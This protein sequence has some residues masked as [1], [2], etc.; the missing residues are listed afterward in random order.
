MHLGISYKP[1]SEASPLVVN[2]KNTPRDFAMA[3][4]AAALP[5]T[6][7]AHDGWGAC[8]GRKLLLEKLNKG[9]IGLDADPLAVYNAY[10]RGEKL[11]FKYPYND[12]FTRRFEQLK[13]L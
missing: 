9:E 13:K 5:A 12:D 1:Y 2:P 6:S 8:R 7:A 4:A 10:C 3:E 11:F